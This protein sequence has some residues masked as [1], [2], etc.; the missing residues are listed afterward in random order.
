MVRRLALI[1]AGVLVAGVL[2]EVLLRVLNVVPE[3]ANPL[4]SFHDSD[5]LLGWRGRPNVRMRFRRPD[6]DTLIE[7]GPDGWRRPDPAPPAVPVLRVLVLGDSFTWGWGVAQGQVFTDL[8]QRRLPAVAIANRGVNAFGT[9][10]EYLLM[11]RELAERHYDVVML[12]FFHNDLTDNID[13]DSGRRPIF[14]LEGDALVPRNQPPEPL[15]TPLQRLFKE[16]SRALDL[17]SF[18]ATQFGRWLNPVE[19]LNIVPEGSEDI[20]YH[21]LPGAAVTMRLLAEMH[22]LAAGNGAQFIL[23]YLPHHSEI[24]HLPS[25]APYLRAVHAL[26]R[27]TAARE[28]IPLVDLAPAFNEAAQA[29]QAVIYPHDAHW[30][31]TGHA[32]AADV[33]LSSPAFAAAVGKGAQ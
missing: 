30:T 15:M 9:S 27:D 18:S 1:L 10:Q 12:M 16:H 5:P 17:I 28:G 8:L 13:P 6:F 26:V 20:D 21:T 24:Q 31:P 4:Y 14:A 29:G 3:V 11:Q 32:L 23:V 19:A 25:R 22:R 2:V 33:L 7:H